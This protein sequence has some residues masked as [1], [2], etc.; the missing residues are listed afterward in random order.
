VF[1]KNQDHYNAAAP[2]NFS[3]IGWNGDSQGP[4][5]AFIID[6]SSPSLTNYSI[7]MFVGLNV[8]PGKYVLQAVYYPNNPQVPVNFYACADVQVI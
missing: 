4:L 6:T 7:S 5:Q 8:V 1:Q 3:L 2:G